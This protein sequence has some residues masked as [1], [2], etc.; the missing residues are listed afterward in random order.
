MLTRFILALAI[1]LPIGAW[2]AWSSIRTEIGI[3]ALSVGAWTA[4]PLEGSPLADPYTKAKVAARG[5]VPLGVGEGV[6]FEATKDAFG[7]PLD[8]ACDY[9]VFGRTPKARIWTLTI[10]EADPETGDGPAL[11]RSDGRVASI[12]SRD[13]VRRETGTFSVSI[14]PTPS[15]GDWLPLARPPAAP[16]PRRDA[17]ATR[18]VPMKIVLRLYDSPVATSAELFEPT[19]PVI[20]RLGCRT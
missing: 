16:R 14:G 13:L 1:G 3:G 11:A 18:P 2:S 6:A 17:P 20:E 8:R 12:T 15:A 5:A 7:R 19:M 10:H 9:R 4:W